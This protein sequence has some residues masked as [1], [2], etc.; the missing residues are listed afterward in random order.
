MWR[1]RALE[2]LLRF[3]GVGGGRQGPSLISPRPKFRFKF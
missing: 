1:L 3:V 2:A